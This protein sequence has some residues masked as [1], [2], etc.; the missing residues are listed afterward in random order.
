MSVW[1]DIA[2]KLEEGG[3]VVV[4]KA[5]LLSQIASLKAQTVSCDSMIIKN[6]K[7]L[8]KA[9]YEAHKDDEANDYAD[10]MATIKE[11]MEKK[12][13]L[14]AQIAELKAAA[15]CDSAEEGAE[16]AEGAEDAEEVVEV[17]EEI[18]EEAAESMEE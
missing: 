17:I 10:F 16:G 13:E 14:N 18:A 2:G 7:E 4:D 12:D 9:Y 1:T 3:K 11:S 5:K 8:G 6:Y 15:A